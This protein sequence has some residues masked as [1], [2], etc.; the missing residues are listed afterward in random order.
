[1]ILHKSR[2][3]L[4]LEAAAATSALASLRLEA[5]AATSVL[6]SLDTPEGLAGLVF[7]KTKNAEFHVTFREHLEKLHNE[8]PEEEPTDPAASEPAS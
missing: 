2:K 4:R 7:E 6:A 1:M 5:T 3:E 8:A